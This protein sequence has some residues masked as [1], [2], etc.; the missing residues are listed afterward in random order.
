V[1][2]ALSLIH[3]DPTLMGR[4]QD[5]DAGTGPA[6]LPVG[7]IAHGIKIGHV[8]NAGVILGLYRH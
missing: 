8:K 6:E 5:W 1:P 4:Y 3:L 7:E 2:Y